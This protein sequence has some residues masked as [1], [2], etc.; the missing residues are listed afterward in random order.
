LGKKICARIPRAACAGVLSVPRGGSQR[1]EKRG[2]ESKTHLFD[3]GFSAGDK[4][5]K[6]ID[7]KAAEPVVKKAGGRLEKVIGKIE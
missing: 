1:K 7:L 5:G 3:L 4:K 2:R 6:K